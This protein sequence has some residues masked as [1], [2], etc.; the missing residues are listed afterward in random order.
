MAN[1]SIRR[2]C[3]DKPSALGKGGPHRIL[4]DISMEIADGEFL[5]V[6]RVEVVRE[7]GTA[8][9]GVVTRVHR[10]LTHSHETDPRRHTIRA[11]CAA[12]EV[13]QADGLHGGVGGGETLE[14][15]CAAG[16]DEHTPETIGV[17][18]P[19]RRI[20]RRAVAGLIVL[21][22]AV[23]PMPVG[24]P[25]DRRPSRIRERLIRQQ[26]GT[27]VLCKNQKNTHRKHGCRVLRKCGIATLFH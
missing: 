25:D 4:H 15:A 3:K 8:G 6:A 17:G 12:T 27:G 2:L 9:I 24:R 22:R 18:Q 19:G 10:T 20:G 16:S 21:P 11:V 23:E 5:D 13:E 7:V 1:V 14:E 26:A